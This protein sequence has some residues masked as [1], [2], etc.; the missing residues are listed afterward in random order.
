MPQFRV[1]ESSG[2]ITVDAL[3]TVD[4][5][6]HQFTPAEQAHISQLHDPHSTAGSAVRDTVR[7]CLIAL[8]DNI[9]EEISHVDFTTTQS[10]EDTQKIR[11]R[12]AADDARNE[13]KAALEEQIEANKAAAEQAI[14]AAKAEGAASRDDEVTKLSQTVLA[15]QKELRQL[16]ADNEPQQAADE[17]RRVARNQARQN[18]RAVKA[19]EQAKAE[20]THQAAARRITSK[21]K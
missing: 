20:R 10:L 12:L 18:Q 16:K 21:R 1:L 8:C 2:A 11:V 7:E 6:S 14:A 3:V 13:T 19:A 15:L 9:D 5:N 4:A 17:A